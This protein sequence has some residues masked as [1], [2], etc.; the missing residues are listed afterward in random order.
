MQK[1]FAGSSLACSAL[2]LASCGGANPPVTKQNSNAP[3]NRAQ[4]SL[5]HGTS[6]SANLGVAS[7]HG[8]GTAA[9]PPAGAGPATSAPAKAPVETPELDAKI[10]KATAKSKGSGASAAD[11]KAAAAAFLARGN[12][13]Y[14]AGNPMLYRY[15]LGDFRRVLRYDPDNGEAKEKIKQIEDIYTYSVKKPIPDNGLNDEQ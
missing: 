1:L 12:F 5:Q 9:P 14:E 8:G 2:L 11:K 3:A 4:T 10:E 13:Y 6:P 15:A 7:S